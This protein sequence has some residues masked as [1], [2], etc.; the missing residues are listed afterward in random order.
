MSKATFIKNI[1][2]CRW[3]GYG[4]DLY[5]NPD[6]SA[7]IRFDKLTHPLPYKYN[8]KFN[9]VDDANEFIEDNKGNNGLQTLRAILDKSDIQE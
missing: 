6:L 8:L 7:S 9:N 5:Q 4:A 3:N 2:G 1:G